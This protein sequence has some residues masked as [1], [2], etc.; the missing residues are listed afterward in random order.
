MGCRRGKISLCTAIF[1]HMLREEVR[2]KD[3]VET[4]VS[5]YHTAIRG[6]LV[7]NWGKLRC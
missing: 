3:G 7:E 6:D 1:Q 5:V 2:R 4:L